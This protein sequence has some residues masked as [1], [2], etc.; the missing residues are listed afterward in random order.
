M[1][2]FI[3]ARER[4]LAALRAELVG[5][6]PAGTEIN[7]AGELVFDTPQAASGPYR[8]AGTG[9]EILTGDRPGKRYGVGVLY[10]IGLELEIDPGNSAAE[11]DGLDATAASRAEENALDVAETEAIAD[12][13]RDDDTDRLTARRAIA[14]EAADDDLPLTTANGFRPSSLGLSFVCDLSDADHLEVVLSGARYRGKDIAIR[15]TGAR[16]T[17]WLREP[18]TI[19]ARFPRASLAAGRGMVPADVE[20]GT[21]PDGIALDLA[22][23]TRPLGSDRYLLTVSAVN[24]SSAKAPDSSSIFQVQLACKAGGAAIFC[25]YEERQRVGDDPELAS[26]ALLYRDVP[27]FAIGHG[28]S[29]DWTAPEGSHRATE[30]LTAALPEVELPSTT[31]EIR[32]DEGN[33]IAVPMAPLAGIVADDDGVQ[34]LRDIVAGYTAW[35]ETQEARIDDVS[36]HRDAA[37][38]HMRLCREARDRMKDGIDF[39]VSGKDPLAAEAFRLANWAML[40]QQQRSG[41]PLRETIYDRK[42]KRIRI[43]G[44]FTPRTEGRG[45]WRPFQIAFVLACL[46]STAQGT[47]PDRGVV[48][49]IFFPTG[50]GKTEAYLALTA[51]SIFYRR[52]RDG[53]DAGVDVLMR[54][55]LRLLTAQQ[56]QRASALICAMEHIRKQHVESLGGHQISIGVWLG[57]SVTPNSR[58]DAVTALRKLIRDGAGENPFILLRCPWCAAQMGPIK[59]SQGGRPVK[60]EPKIAGYVA[61]EESVALICPDAT[62]EFH[63][64]LPVYVI[65][66][67]VYERRPSLV[68]GTVD[69]FAMLAFRPGARRLF[70]LTGGGDREVSPPNLIVQDE[71][72]LISGPLGSMVGLYET[73]I[74]ELATDR[75]SGEPVPPKIVGST[76][77]IRRYEKQVRDLYARDE[78]A[79]FPPRGIDAGDSYFA[80]YARDGEGKLEHGRVYV[81]V[82]GAGLGSVQ[83]AQVRTFTTLLQ[84]A[85]MLDADVRDPW[86]TLLVFFNSL[87]ELGTSVSLLQSDIPDYFRVVAKRLGLDS[88][89]VRRIWR[90]TELTG[91]L[92]ND[93]VPAAIEE[94]EVRFT[95]EAN[96]AVDVCLASNIVEVGVDI[97]RLS[98]MSVVGQPKTTAQYIQATGR[99]GRSWW[100]RPGLVATIY[101]ASK[102]RD[103]SH[104]E[105]FRSY[106]ERLYAQ[107]EPTSVTPFAPPVLDRALHAVIV[108]Y[109]RQLAHDGTGPRPVPDDLLEAARQLLQ[110]RVDHVDPDESEQLAAVFAK[111]AEQW[112]KWGYSDWLADNDSEDYAL[113]RYAGSYASREEQLLSWAVPTSLRNVD[114]ECRAEVT[115]AYLLAE[116]YERDRA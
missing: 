26:L 53:N 101:S 84:A 90:D 82:H 104:F 67:D 6:S 52:L 3:E 111:R 63:K 97:D 39:L 44:G 54:Y 7:C 17:W 5:P 4:L 43:E 20:K 40:L 23:F 32:D 30:V 87:R 74:Q 13:D 24:R 14:R 66:E 113:L 47:A 25:P 21:L 38:D 93:E 8:Q 15:S 50:G 102:P 105:K 108:A 58:R 22:A 42:A 103:R 100:E 49:L 73:V 51:F 16:W 41:H 64:G 72:H 60:T 83:T 10:P 31:P 1:P 46:R 92:R 29:A 85:Y 45:T 75:R 69:K 19:S 9:E 56:F 59:A 91:R 116:E 95:E 89:D 96:R 61:R 62:C 12:K 70:G 28:C 11:D 37:V 76:A 109:I 110:D 77:T 78:V 80:S 2:E 98:L 107:V 55:T 48:E 114:A 35:I 34:S 57:A 65:D 71:L 88:A 94:L 27:A 18:F 115:Q 86:W 81:G 99:V 79:L 36:D 68:I 33:T 112:R 106:H